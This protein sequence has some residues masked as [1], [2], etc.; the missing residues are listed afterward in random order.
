MIFMPLIECIRQNQAAAIRSTCD[1]NSC[2]INF[3]GFR[4]MVILKGE[5]TRDECGIIA[6]TKFGNK[7]C[8]CM[9]F[10]SNE[11]KA[12]AIVELSKTKERDPSAVKQKFDNSSE[13]V[14]TILIACRKNPNTLKIAFIYVTNCVKR[15]KK[16]IFNTISESK[17]FRGINIRLY[18]RPYPILIANSGTV[19]TPADVATQFFN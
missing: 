3:T 4:D 7:M 9:F 5:I 12:L 8:D 16:R 14:R 11:I 6:S 1:E 17:H 15:K 10:L 19:L 13:I 18:G 2:L